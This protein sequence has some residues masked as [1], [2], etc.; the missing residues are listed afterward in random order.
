MSNQNEDVLEEFI[1][2]STRKH[3]LFSERIE[4]EY[5]PVEEIRFL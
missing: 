2:N 5:L 4:D 1:A 3:K